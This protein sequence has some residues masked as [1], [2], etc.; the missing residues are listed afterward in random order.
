M[1]LAA[2]RTDVHR[3]VR[4]VEVVTIVLPHLLSLIC[5]K[6]ILDCF[7]NRRMQIKGF[8]W[9]IEGERQNAFITSIVFYSANDMNQ[10]IISL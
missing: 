8:G 7:Q 6:I 9:D 10:K 5:R 1:A 3:K 2:C 4:P